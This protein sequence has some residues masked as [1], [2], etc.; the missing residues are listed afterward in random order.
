[1]AEIPFDSSGVSTYPPQSL[2]IGQSAIYEQLQDFLSPA[3]NDRPSAFFVYGDWGTGKSA[4][5]HQIVAERTGHSRGWLRPT[6]EGA[7]SQDLLDSIDRGVL[8]IMLPLS[9][10]VGDLTEETAG[11][12]AFDRAIEKVCNN[13]GQLY[14]SLR[15]HLNGLKP[16]LTTELEATRNQYGDLTTRTTELL[17]QLYAIESI[18]RL[19][20]IIDEVEQF[21]TT[22]QSPDETTD[23]G[24]NQL[25]LESFLSGIKTA[26][27]PDQRTYQGKFEVD[28]L[29]LCTPNIKRVVEQIGGFS[30]RKRD[31]DIQ[32]PSVEEALK[33]VEQKQKE[34]DLSIDPDAAKALFFASFNNYGWFDTGMYS[35]LLQHATQESPSSYEELIQNRPDSFDTLFDKEYI[36]GIKEDTQPPTDLRN[37][38]LTVIHQILPTPLADVSSEFNIDVDE[39][40]AYTEPTGIRPIG[41]MR[42]AKINTSDVIRRL[43]ANHG[44][45]DRAG[46]GDEQRE[47][48]RGSDTINFRVLE[49][50]LEVFRIEGSEYAMYTN[51]DDLAELVRFVAEGAVSQETLDELVAFFQ[52]LPDASGNYVGPTIQFLTRWNHRWRQQEQVLQWL[53]DDLWA[54][55]QEKLAVVNRQEPDRLV[56][57][58]SYIRFP[59]TRDST[60]FESITNIDLPHTVVSVADDPVLDV[61]PADKAIVMLHDGDK[62]S[63]RDA[64]SEAFDTNRGELPLVYLLFESEQERETVM[65]VLKQRFTTKLPLI[66]PR[67][68]T[69]RE[70]DRKFSLQFS[71]LNDVFSTDDLLVEGKKRLDDR[72]T[73]FVENDEQWRSRV[74][75]D[76]WIVRPAC[77]ASIPDAEPRMASAL[78]TLSDRNPPSSFDND[79]V[80]AWD[81]YTDNRKE[82]LQWTDENDSLRV[83]AQVPKILSVF[84]AAQSPMTAADLRTQML[85][86]DS[87]LTPERGFETVVNV[88]ASLGA[89]IE[90]SDGYVL[91]DGDSLNERATETKTKLGQKGIASGTVDDIK[92][93]LGDDTLVRFDV[94]EE[95]LQKFDRE[96]EEAVDQIETTDFGILTTPDAD[97]S[98]WYETLDTARQLRSVFRKGYDPY[99]EF[100]AADYQS[101]LAA[102]IQN[103]KSDYSL[104]YRLAFLDWFQKTLTE[105]TD[106]FSDT[107]ED[108]RTELGEKYST[109]QGIEFPADPIREIFADIEADLNLEDVDLS[110]ELT[111]PTDDSFSALLSLGN[112]DQVID[113]IEWY[114]K[115]FESSGHKE[116]P[117]TTFKQAYAS[118]EEVLDVWDTAEAAKEDAE[119]FVEESEFEEELETGNIQAGGET[120]TLEG[121]WSDL[122]ALCTNPDSILAGVDLETLLAEIESALSYLPAIKE[123]CKA[124]LEDA[125]SD[126]QQKIEEKC[127][128]E[129]LRSLGR[130]PP[131]SETVNIEMGRVTE[132]DMYI[133]QLS[134]VDEL[135]DEI[136][137]RGQELLGQ[138]NTALEKCWD[139]YKKLYYWE[140]VGAEAMT[141]NSLDDT[142]QNHLKLLEKHNVFDVDRTVR[143]NVSF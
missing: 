37:A 81:S 21:E 60:D 75:D 71:F 113:R 137:S 38:I 34:T 45:E 70:F 59:W 135:E 22:A 72:A 49:D 52:D 29:L 100:D 118:M 98:S 104:Y 20:L 36:R 46:G 87:Q 97:T 9:D 42:T 43:T 80:R 101:G 85:Y 17:T 120:I 114:G 64:V 33:L 66:I 92:E 141:D 18:D 117:W 90:K 32:R 58:F 93:T 50:V 3:N 108:R 31:D 65:E 15:D 109:V 51:E 73:R 105:Q 61:S 139:S 14:E 62:A 25:Q 143:Y 138:I 48:V 82:L 132:P 12:V 53:E 142:T 88:L 19:L 8:P 124:V 1:M 55:L 115:I 106:E 56:E 96:R 122:K 44:F 11:L 24:V 103:N 2:Y 99:D 67:V 89:L 94:T 130:A 125:K 95:Q 76:G 26:I 134:K 136:D 126:I 28:L 107:L 91:T 35:L 5:G 111:Q 127:A 69:D 23:E 47:F 119:R 110:D 112:Y 10:F 6:E 78:I 84:D 7:P 39:L 116:D 27:N 68:L 57:G 131:V 102:E 133:K 121:K 40:M 54:K 86:D 140:D 16:N 79:E 77:P 83:P 13:D 128:I 30:R 74:D 123:Q 63:T 4:L 129:P 41:R